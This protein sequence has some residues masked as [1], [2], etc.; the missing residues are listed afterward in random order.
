MVNLNRIFPWLSIRSKLLIAFAG[1]SIL[2]LTFVGIYGILSNVRTMQ[3]IALENLSHDV[4]TI[5]GKTANFL[6]SIESDLRVLR[7]SAVLERFIS[8]RESFPRG[9]YETDLQEISSELSAFAKAKGIYYQL[10][11]V[12]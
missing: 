7:N 11:M 2:P 9:T 4:Q 5:K 10:R 8:K 1:L 6:E 3:E 12:D